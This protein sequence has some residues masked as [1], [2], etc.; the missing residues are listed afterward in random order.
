M[1]RRTRVSKRQ[2]G[3][4]VEAWRIRS[5]SSLMIIEPSIGV[6]STGGVSIAGDSLQIIGLLSVL[7]GRWRRGG[8]LT[9][10]GLGVATT[11][12]VRDGNVAKSLETVRLHPLWNIRGDI[13]IAGTC[14]LVACNERLGK[15]PRSTMGGCSG[16][17]RSPGSPRRLRTRS[18]RATATRSELVRKSAIAAGVPAGP[19][20]EQVRSNIGP[21]D[22]RRRGPPSGETRYRMAERHGRRRTRTWAHAIIVNKQR[23]HVPVAE[24]RLDRLIAYEHPCVHQGSGIELVDTGEECRLVRK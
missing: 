13:A 15:R 24:L 5:P 19:H 4:R 2:S 23:L 18:T 17:A 6:H 3:S 10:V 1:A 12:H 22:S 21:V 14:L 9:A 7:R 16:C 11:G 20:R 8:L